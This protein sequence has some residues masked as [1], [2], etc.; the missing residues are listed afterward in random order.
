MGLQV[1]AG[2]A[3]TM[4]ANGG[5]GFL[6]Q[7]PTLQL[8]RALRAG[9]PAGVEAAAAGQ[10]CDLEQPVRGPGDAPAERPLTFALREAAKDGDKKAAWAAC[11]RALV[12]KGAGVKEKT[13]AGGHLLDI[14][15]DVGLAEFLLD[16]GAAGCTSAGFAH[17]AGARCSAEED[18]SGGI[19][20]TAL[21]LLSFVAPFDKDDPLLLLGLCGALVAGHTK[22]AQ[23]LLEKGVPVPP[24]ASLGGFGALFHAAGN[25]DVELCEALLK[26]GELL[27]RVNTSLMQTPF[28]F[29]AMRGC[30]KAAQFLMDRGAKIDTADDAFGCKA[31]HYWCR[32]KDA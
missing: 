14:R 20:A 4:E 28:H 3:A 7:L 12:N 18:R 22:T 5:P 6:K 26:R 19:D 25:D 23:A 17:V 13:S 1:N 27:D 30:W 24:R 9:D 8:H 11:A 29:A 10:G 16:K 31:K 21:K 2:L 32:R 15:V